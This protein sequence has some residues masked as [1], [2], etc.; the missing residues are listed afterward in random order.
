MR[1]LQDVLGLDHRFSRDITFGVICLAFDIVE[2][3]ARGAPAP[4][5]G[6]GLDLDGFDEATR[7][8]ADA[9]FRA[10]RPRPTDPVGEQRRLDRLVVDGRHS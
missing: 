5:L 9:L 3:L 6:H 4:A 1:M 7:L 2:S 8:E 10:E